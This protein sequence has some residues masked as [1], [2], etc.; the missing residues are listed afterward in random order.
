MLYGFGCI[1]FKTTADPALKAYYESLF[2]TGWF[3]ESILTQT[4]IVHI[5]RTNRIPFFQSRASW[6]LTLTTLAVIAVA[7]ALPYSPLAGPLGLIP[8]PRAF[9][10]WMLATVIGY[11]ILTHF[12]KTRFI[13]RYGAD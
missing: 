2:H 4:L 10:L 12:V 7:C 6:P 8:L 3:V 1:A 13:R 11:S 9:W 5:I